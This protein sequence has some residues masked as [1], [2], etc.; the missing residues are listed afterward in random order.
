[1]LVAA[2]LMVKA[3]IRAVALAGLVV[4]A[5]AAAP[6]LAPDYALQARALAPGVW[7]VEGTNAD[8]SRANGCNIINTAFIA[9][10]DGVLVINSGPSRRYGEALRALIARTTSEPIRE[11]VQLNLHPDHGLGH[12]AFADVPRRATAATRAG[13]Q[14]EGRAFEDNLYRLCGDWMAGTRLLPPDSPVPLGRQRMGRRDLEWIELQGHTGSD[15]VLIDHGSGIVFAGGLVFRDRIPTTPHARLDD[16]QRSLDALQ[17]AL[18]PHGVLVPSHGP[19]RPDAQALH[20]TRG[21]LLW[22][23]GHLHASA[24]R[25]LD[26]NELLQQGLPAPFA[27]W[28]AADTEYVRN[29]AHLYPGFEREAL[30]ALRTRP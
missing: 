14:R 17:A 3:A 11:L 19:V 4:G 8:F 15:L 18:P 23:Q 28:A 9:T 27:G 30:G 16:W 20:Q 6:D 25:G 2:V 21:Y 7:V 22:L 29:L 13:V 5:Q 10:G 24:L 12:Q 1:V 26:V